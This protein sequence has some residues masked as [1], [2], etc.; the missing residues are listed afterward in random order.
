MAFIVT[1]TYNSLPEFNSGY[2]PGSRSVGLLVNNA[3][4]NVCHSSRL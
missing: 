1:D 2:G 3:T 4:L